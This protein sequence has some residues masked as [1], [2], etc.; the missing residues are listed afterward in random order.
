MLSLSDHRPVLLL[1]LLANAWCVVVNEEIAEVLHPG[2]I[3]PVSLACNETQPERF[4]ADLAFGL[5][6]FFGVAALVL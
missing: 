1:V 2:L 6:S 5:V 3:L 4:H